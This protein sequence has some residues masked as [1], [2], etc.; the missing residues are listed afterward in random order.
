MAVREKDGAMTKTT[1][2]VV[3]K[4]IGLIFLMGI[5]VP[6]LENLLYGMDMLVPALLVSKA[7]GFVFISLTV[8][9]A[10]KAWRGHD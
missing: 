1:A 7:F 10:Y 8:Y 4:T 5:S 2:R 3:L 6:F 9:V